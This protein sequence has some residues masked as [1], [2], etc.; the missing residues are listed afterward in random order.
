MV[1]STV[2]DDRPHPFSLSKD[3]SSCISYRIIHKYALTVDLKSIESIRPF[4]CHLIPNECA[5]TKPP[6]HIRG[7][8][9][10]W[11]DTL[12]AIYIYYRIFDEDGRKAYNSNLKK[13]SSS[14]RELYN[15]NIDHLHANR[16]FVD[17]RESIIKLEHIVIHPY[18][19]PCTNIAANDEIDRIDGVPCPCCNFLLTEKVFNSKQ[20]K[21]KRG[22]NK[23]VKCLQ[24]L[25][26]VEQGVKQVYKD[27]LLNNLI[28]QQ[29]I[30]C[31]I[32]IQ[33]QHIQVHDPK[34]KSFLN[35]EFGEFISSL[36]LPLVSMKFK[37]QCITV[38]PYTPAD[39]YNR[40]TRELSGRCPVQVEWPS[41][42][43]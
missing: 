38:P 28:Q 41:Y 11:N 19:L 43:S 5:I 31:P 1:I 30:E 33:Y 16:I 22:I 40:R 35:E 21:R 34:M 4:I 17:G 26:G 32:H 2:I 39:M 14:R 20:Y 9:D 42:T 18:R 6:L 23:N 7:G 3:D 37:I 36:L 29:V 8:Y 10:N 27:N 25:V 15:N 12:H 13:L 24:C